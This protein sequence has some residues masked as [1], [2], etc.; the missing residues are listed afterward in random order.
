MVYTRV[1]FNELDKSLIDM[2]FS[3]I[4]RSNCIYILN[5]NTTMLVYVDDL[6][7]FSKTDQI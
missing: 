7:T 6:I 1:W 3:K 2:G 5:K 4:S